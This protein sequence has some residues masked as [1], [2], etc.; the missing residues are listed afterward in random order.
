MS[1]RVAVGCGVMRN[2]A[3]CCG[4]MRTDADCRYLFLSF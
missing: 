2:D 4:T 3:D 1:W